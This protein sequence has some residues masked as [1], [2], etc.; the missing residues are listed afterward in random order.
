MGDLINKGIGWVL[1]FCSNL[2]GDNYFFAIL[3]FAVVVEIILLPFGILQQKNSIKQARLR[4]KEMAIRKKYAGRD[5]KPTQQKMAQEIQE[6]YQ[7]EG[8]N[9]MSGCL[10]LL[11]QFPLLIALYNVVI[12]PLKY[13]CGLSAETVSR[14]NLT[15]NALSGTSVGMGR[16]TM[17]LLGHIKQY[18]YEAFSSAGSDFT[19]EIF[20]N[21]PNLD[22]FGIFDLSLA[23]QDCMNFAA[24]AD[25]T[26]W[27]IIAIPV[28]TFLAYF[29]S[30]KITRKFSYQPMQD[31]QQAQTGCSNKTMDIMMPLLSVFISFGVPAALGV[32][33]IF[34][35]LLG[36]VKQIAL[37]YAMPIPKFSD[38]E[39]KAAEKEY[40]SKSEKSGEV[41]AEVEA[42][43]VKP[44]K[45]K[46]AL[47]EAPIK[48]D[49]R[50]G[51]GEDKN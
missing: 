12:D 24:F 48:K 13:I 50:N 25:P 39:Y 21:M 16:G 3:I 47:S 11:I 23:P 30:M 10:P 44:E 1:K 27:I 37:S 2:V 51:D 49:E 34:K 19:P 46:K 40:G 41:V 31:N 17:S 26:N 8:Y 9:P 22:V 7:K 35:S 43:E 36:V 42:E 32:Y 28:L 15:V 4:P 6:L 5:D 14:I 45:K 18:G 33:W 29:F 20:N 38:A